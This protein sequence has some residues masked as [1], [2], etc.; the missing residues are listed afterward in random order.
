MRPLAVAIVAAIFSITG[1]QGMATTSQD[2][3]TS[4]SS[5]VDNT[6][7]DWPLK[8]VQHNF[9]ARCFS[10]YECTVTY[11]RLTSTPGREHELRPS[12]SEM[13]PD[14]LKNA[15]T[16]QI[17]I[18]NFPP[19]AQVR[20]RSKDGTQLETSVDIG[21]I[22]KDQVVLHNVPRDQ[23]SANPGVVDVLLVVNDRTI[24]VYMRAFVSAHVEQVVDGRRG[25]SRRE[26]ILAW[27]R[28]Y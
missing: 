22:F 9:G 7:A 2:S 15:M 23:V 26:L 28:T 13:H 24:N 10:T 21:E 12:L 18:M 20:W 25:H 17:G 16:G 8:F 1:C 6:V 19:P 4:G 11:N 3:P 5:K 27:S 14:A